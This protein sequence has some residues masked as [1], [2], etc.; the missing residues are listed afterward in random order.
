MGV[1]DPENVFESVCAGFK[2]TPK[3]CKA[4]KL[5]GEVPSGISTG[6]LLLIIVGLILLNVLLILCY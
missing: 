5:G 3:E 2:N 4:H 6:R 1:L